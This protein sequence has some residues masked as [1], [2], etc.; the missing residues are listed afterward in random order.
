MIHARA[1]ANISYKSFVKQRFVMSKS[2]LAMMAI[3][4]IFYIASLIYFS[5]EGRT[6]DAL[7]AFAFLLIPP[8][9]LLVERNLH[10]TMPPLFA[11][12]AFYLLI[13]ST[14]GSSYDL[15]TH[16]PA[17]DELLHGYSGFFFSCIGFVL[18]ESLMGEPKDKKSFVCA[19][20][21]GV[22]FCLM[23]GF[24]WEIFE[25]AGSTLLG[26]DM[27]EDAIVHSFHSYFLS[28]THSA[29]YSVDNIVNTVITL[30]DGRTIVIDGYLDLGLIDTLDDMIVCLIGAAAYLVFIPVLRKTSYRLYR[31][32]MPRY[33]KVETCKHDEYMREPH[34]AYD[35]AIGNK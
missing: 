1:S 16:V 33:A 17:W 14:L 4:I 30:A 35:F 2:Y 34:A 10:I 18:F 12:G 3:Y 24:L 25:W 19:M 27:E 8:V 31:T 7:L 15:Y 32:I 23:I 28:G 13:G 21:F 26:A 29:A 22:A 6:R 20:L 9:M 11:L 5:V